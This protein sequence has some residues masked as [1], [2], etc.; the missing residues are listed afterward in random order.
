LFIRNAWYVAAWADEIGEAPLARRICNEPVVLFRDQQNRVA[1][2]LDMCCHRGA[3]LHM[4]KVVEEGLQC[5]Y[6]GLVF[7]RSGAC[8]RVPGQTHILERTRVRGFPVV[9]QDAFVWIW[10]GDPAKAD[11]STIVP[12]PYHNDAKN[13]PHRHTMY[14]IK[15]AAMLMVDNL[16]DLTHLG[17]VHVSTIGGNPAQHVDAKMETQR[18]PLGL[19]FTRWMLN[20]LPPPTYVR[21]VGFQGRIDRCQRFEFVAPASVLQWTGAAEAGA[22]RDGDTSGSP[23]EFRL[24]HALTPETDTTCFYFWSAANG[25]RQDEPAATEQFFEQV[26][27]AFMED[28]TVVEGQQVRLAEL[29]ESA[30]VD[31]ATDAARLHMRRTVE[32]M[33]QEEAR[34]EVAAE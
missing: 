14:P 22:Y 23:L 8:V 2:L 11:V 20:S 24:F 30:L 9:E 1:A 27:A 17:Y 32:R 28:K 15:A 33:V 7:D 18:T 6:H 19:K 31:I 13:W 29:G 16:M 21:A 12:W 34:L 25:F 4:G 26:A 3:P 5:G 10:M